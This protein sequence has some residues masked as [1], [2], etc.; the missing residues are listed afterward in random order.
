MLI[1]TLPLLEAK[2]SAEIENIV[3]TTDQL[4]KYAQ[5]QDNADPATKE[6]LRYRADLQRGYPSMKDRPLCTTT[7][8]GAWAVGRGHGRYLHFPRAAM[9]GMMNTD[10]SEPPALGPK[11][12]SLALRA[13]SAAS[14]SDSSE[15]GP[16]SLTPLASAIFWMAQIGRAHV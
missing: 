16:S 5:G 2:D 8:V 1:N 3:T 15:T 14:P 7:A 9:Y 12:S 10:R 6:A 11:Q 4:F 13:M